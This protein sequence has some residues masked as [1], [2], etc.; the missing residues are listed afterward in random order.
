[1]ATHWG[2]ITAQHDAVSPL[3]AEIKSQTLMYVWGLRHSTFRA[4]I[5][6]PDAWVDEFGQ[7]HVGVV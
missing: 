3:E 7:P 6:S 5:C 1:M 2:K 4:S